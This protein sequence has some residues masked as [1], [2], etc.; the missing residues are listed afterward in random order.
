MKQSMRLR[1]GKETWQAAIRESSTCG[2]FT[3][4]FLR[5]LMLSTPLAHTRALLRSVCSRPR[6]GTLFFHCSTRALAHTLLFL[7]LQTQ[8][9]SMTSPLH[10]SFSTSDRN[11]VSKQNK[12][13]QPCLLHFLTQSASLVDFP[14]LTFLLMLRIYFTQ[15]HTQFWAVCRS[16]HIL[17]YVYVNR[18]LSH[19]L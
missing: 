9:T 8:L 17:L 4:F 5:V 10:Q 18:V 11:H 19:L 12:K 15:F 2:S 13:N 16:D 14:L 7:C 3:F 6:H 1:L